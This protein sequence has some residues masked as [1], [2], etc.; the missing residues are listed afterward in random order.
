MC[1]CFEKN[2]HASSEI[3]TKIYQIFLEKMVDCEF[4]GNISI[5][6]WIWR[7]SPP[8]D[9][10]FGFFVYERDHEHAVHDIDLALLNVVEVFG[11]LADYGHRVDVD[12]EYLF[13]LANAQNEA[14][15]DVVSVAVLRR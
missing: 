7:V 1:A 3:I 12:D 10:D 5:I 6:S 15:E 14:I 8:H 9:F 13:T 11:V 4:F 2:N